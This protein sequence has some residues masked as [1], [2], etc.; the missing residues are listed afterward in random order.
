MPELSGLW[1]LWGAKK[2]EEVSKDNPTATSRKL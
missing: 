2:M 1:T